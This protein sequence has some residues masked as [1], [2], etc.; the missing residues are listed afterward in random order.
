MANIQ[1]TSEQIALRQQQ[2]SQQEQQISKY[3]QAIPKTTEQQLRG[4]VGRGKQINPLKALLKRR[5]WSQA[6]GKV[7]K[8]QEQLEQYKEQLKTY[9]KQFEEYK[10]TERGKLQYAKEMGLKG[11]PIYGKIAK[12]YVRGIMGYE[13]STP[14]GKV[15]DWSPKQRRIKTEMKLQKLAGEEIEKMGFTSPKAFYSA[16][17]KGL[18]SEEQIQKGLSEGL[19]FLEEDLKKSGKPTS[20]GEK[21]QIDKELQPIKELIESE[22]Q[23][24]IYGIKKESIYSKLKNLISLKKPETKEIY[25]PELGGFVSASEPSGQAT[26]IIRPP[27]IQEF[28]DIEQAQYKGSW[29]RIKTLVSPKQTTES[30]YLGDK[31]IV[32]SPD[33]ISPTY[34]DPFTGTSIGGTAT[35]GT[36]I[37]R[38]PIETD[39]SRGIIR[40]VEE[41]LF[42]AASIPLT[43][44][45]EQVYLPDTQSSKKFTELIEPSSPYL[46]T[47]GK[48]FI[49][50]MREQQTKHKRDIGKYNELT[51]LR[52]TGNLDKI[53]ERELKEVIKRLERGS[54]GTLQDVI[55]KS[56]RD[57]KKGKGLYSTLVGGQHA[58]GAGKLALGFE[59]GFGAVGKGFGLLGASLPKVTGTVSQLNWLKGAGV[60]SGITLGGSFATL[61]GA[62][63]YSKRGDIGSAIGAGVG[64]GVGL[65]GGQLV[66]SITG[67]VIKPTLKEKEILVRQKLAK[68]ER[69]ISKFQ[70]KRFKFL[71]GETGRDPFTGKQLKSTADYEGLGM[72]YSQKISR[73]EANILFDYLDDMGI[74]KN[75]PKKDF[76]KD[77]SVSIGKLRTRL[78]EKLVI[79]KGSLKD[80][81]KVV[82]LGKFSD[83]L[84]FIGKGRAEVRELALGF[85]AKT[86]KQLKVVYQVDRLG[87]P[88]KS[89]IELQVVTSGKGQKFSIVEPFTKGRKSKSIIK[90]DAGDFIF[91]KESPIRVGEPSIV[92][93]TNSKQFGERRLKIRT[94]EIEFRQKDPFRRLR[95]RGTPKDIL[96]ALESRVSKKELAK[97]YREGKTIQKEYLIDVIQKGSEKAKTKL[98]YLREGDLGIGN[99]GLDKIDDSLMVSRLKVKGYS[100]LSHRVDKIDDIISNTKNIYSKE[101]TKPYT[102]LKLKSVFK[103]KPLTIITPPQKI[104]IIP[105]SK[106][107]IKIKTP[108]T[109]IFKR[110]GV[111]HLSGKSIRGPLSF[112]RKDRGVIGYTMIEQ[113]IS[114]QIDSVVSPSLY[115]GLTQQIKVGLQEKGI[116]KQNLRL[117]PK[118]IQ[119]PL[120]SITQI[121]EPLLR[122]K[123]IQGITTITKTTQTKTPLTITPRII[124]PTQQTQRPQEPRPPK[125]PMFWLPMDKKKKKG[126]FVKRQ[127][128]T[129]EYLAITKR[130]GK[131]VII[132]RAKTIRKAL[133]I[134]KKKALTTLGAKVKI[135][136]TKGK[137]IQLAPDKLF[138]RSKV[139]PLAL[140]Q[141][142]EKR[143]GSLGERREIK[144]TRGRRKKPFK[145]L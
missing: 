29:E 58:Y 47:G 72:T 113:E 26:A 68:M 136:T 142:R 141:R 3:K 110:E 49:E 92:K 59:L 132:G 112:E 81:K 44:G 63:E 127:K 111:S 62:S 65:F 117:T 91:Y 87:K 42:P 108:T 95:K 89:S 14:Y 85:Q 122:P 107:S 83:D 52:D 32:W 123:I 18:L 36:G 69:E 100:P 82:E 135:T 128:R 86:G 11:K 17:K 22:T 19:L 31:E 126:L 48:K 38:K 56:T 118:Q 139:D 67:G 64:T 41:I 80:I 55:F 53:K 16:T 115:S 101:I 134:G 137:Q 60:S 102:S 140:V 71:R 88:I 28:K 96:G 25:S 37:E 144:I 33:K 78:P 46:G 6:R 103:G 30:Y 124:Q 61:A 99:V 84:S 130:Y 8:A 129:D 138:R 90:T 73:Q 12:G 93:V 131:E 45:R 106:P 20:M 120:N 97:I 43:M 94:S 125:K 57:T 143:L 39:Y 13:Y 34:K 114:P 133:A 54:Q 50:F 40:R 2:I 98:S 10:R 23:P 119:E 104:K 76:L 145:I 77:A 5:K 79:Q 121:S 21:A 35:I 51:L 109:S 27:T 105:K 70:Q 116:S 7:G 66:S 9:E 15:T 4:Q 74:A 75:L 1:E 24:E